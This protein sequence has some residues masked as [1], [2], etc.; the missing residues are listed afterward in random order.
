MNNNLSR[1]DFI[2]L[3]TMALGAVAMRPL[4]DWFPE[5]EGFPEDLFGVGR[6]CTRQI[7]IYA[8]AS[9]E[10]E[11]VRTHGRDELIPIYEE[12]INPE[13]LPN[14]PRWYRVVGGYAHSAHIQRVEGRHLNEPL[15]WVP[16]E[17]WL[18]EITVPYTRAYR[19]TDL[20][21]WVPLYRLYYQSA[22][23]VTGVEAGPNGDPWYK[24]TDELLHID[25][26]VPARHVRII[27]KEELT[28]ISPHVPW[29]DKRIEVSLIDQELFAYEKEEVVLH[30]LISSGI[31]SPGGTSNGV[32]TATPR[33]RFN[34]D[35]KMPSK[36]MG[37][38]K[39]TADIHA[40]E[41]P[42][43]PWVCFFHETGVAFHGTYWHHNFGNKM[44]HGCVNMTMEDAKWLY[45]WALPET[46]IN[47]WERRG[48]GTRVHVF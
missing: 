47:E 12:I 48:F 43:V 34:I 6:V 11:V 44:S 2:K 17:G 3:S 13:Y 25:Y 42:G 1:R 8:E 37:D 27:T 39:M 15:S 23:W 45:R 16:E 41:L 14:A 28:P 30:T 32:P 19:A 4:N 26:H 31:P 21:G 29:E 5:G 36:H 46:G 24:I 18:G 10:S 22:H 7:D 20:Y 9:R 33:G 35:V 40:Y 38:G